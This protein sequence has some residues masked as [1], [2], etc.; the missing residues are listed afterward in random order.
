MTASGIY[1]GVVS[2]VRLRPRP[3][4]LRY[5]IFML[6]LDL[7][8]LDGLDARLKR[9][10]VGRFALT[11][12]S[13]K[14]HLD[15]SGRDLRGQVEAIL[16]AAGLEGGGPVRLLAMPRILGGTFNPLTVWF[17]H[18][19]D[20]SLSAV[21]YEV[22]NTFGESH[23]Y[24]IPAAPTNG[25]VLS[26]AIDKGFYVSPFMDMDL[27][28][29]FRIRPPGDRVAVSIDVSDAEG[30]VLTA[31]FAGERR[32]M[33]DANLLAAWLGRPMTSLGVLAAI[34]WEA[35]WMWLKGE[36][37]RQRP[38]PPAAPVTLAPAAV[39]EFPGPH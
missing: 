18:R 3:H 22:R 29:A 8:E 36:P 37:I 32:E 1:A 4:R 39:R 27:S 25:E 24:L 30:P 19:R 23:S 33:T 31:A 34:H 21:L 35:L 2:H 9:F 17:L 7:D 16:E 5:R 15:H 13:P 6:L 28:Y 14:D 20:G 11:G 26:Q 38:P 12:F 10:A